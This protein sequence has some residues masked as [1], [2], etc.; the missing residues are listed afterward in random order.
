MRRADASG[1]RIAVILGDDE[2][3][4]G[5]VSVKHLREEVPQVRVKMD[6]MVGRVRGM[7]PST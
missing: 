4:A 5:E 2:V 7:L 3:D 6:D 1:A